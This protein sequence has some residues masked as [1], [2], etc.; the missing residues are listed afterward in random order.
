MGQVNGAV[1]DFLAEKVVAHGAVLRLV[2]VHGVLGECDAA[3]VVVM[4]RNW[5]VCGR[6]ELEIIE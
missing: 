5:R 3:V 6:S 4:A 2:V 1:F